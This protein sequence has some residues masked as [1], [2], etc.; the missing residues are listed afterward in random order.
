MQTDCSSTCLTSSRY[1]KPAPATIC[2]VWKNHHVTCCLGATSC[3]SMAISNPLTGVFS[4]WHWVFKKGSVP[5]LKFMASTIT[6]DLSSAGTCCYYAWHW[7]LKCGADYCAWPL[8]TQCRNK[9]LYYCRHCI[10]RS[11]C[12]QPAL[13]KELVS[14][15]KNFKHPSAMRQ[16]MGC[17]HYT[18]KPASSYSLNVPGRRVRF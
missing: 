11:K 1:Q 5:W 15:I 10:H 12:L 16:G 13:S 9:E 7:P 4:T 2:C 17:Y 14:S 3:W 18:L 6:H 8:R